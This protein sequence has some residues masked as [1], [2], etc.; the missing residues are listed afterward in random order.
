V[1]CITVSDV[2]AIL[3]GTE[4]S[5]NSN[6]IYRISFNAVANSGF[7]FGVAQLDIGSN[8]LAQQ[9]YAA[10]LDDALAATA[11]NQPT[12]NRLIAYNGHS[13][14]DLDPNLSSTYQSDKD[15]LNTTVFSRQAAHNI[16]DTYTDQ[17]ITGDPLIEIQNFLDAMDAA[18]GTDSVFAYNNAQYALALAAITSIDNRFGNLNQTT[19]YFQT[20]QPSSIGDVRDRFMS[21]AGAN[22]GQWD[23]VEIGANLLSAADPHYTGVANTISLASA[24]GVLGAEN[25]DD[26]V[27]RFLKAQIGNCIDNVDYVGSDAAGF[28][29]GQFTVSGAFSFSGGIF[30]SSGGFPGSANTSSSF[31]VSNNTPG[32]VNLTATAHSAF[33]GAGV[34]HDA[35]VVSFTFENNNPNVGGIKFDVVFGSD[36]Y[37]E[38]SDTSFVDVAAIYVN[39]VNYALFNN[40]S[41]TPLSVTSPNVS[42]GNFVN[43]TGGAYGVEWDGFSHLL[44]IRAPVH[45]GD[46]LI[47]IGVAD[48]GDSVYDS[49]LYIKDI[50]TLTEGGL[51][52]GV[53]NV[54]DGDDS[55]NHLFATNLAEEINIYGG[56]NT[57]SGSPSQLNGD[58]ITEFGEDDLLVFDGVQFGPEDLGVTFGSAIL[59]VDTNDD[60]SK[61]TTVTLTGNF[62][63]SQ[64]TV[65]Q[66]DGSTE[67]SV[68]L[69][70]PTSAP[71]ITSN[72]G[73]DTGTVSVAENITAV[74]K[75]VAT[76]AESD[77]LTFSISGGADQTK[78][79]INASTGDL[80]FVA[81]PN[82]ESPA[83]VGA[84]NVYNVT[85]QVSDGTSTD[86]QQ[87]A[88]T[89]TN[90]NEPPV[91]TSKRGRRNG[92]CLHSRKYVS[93]YH[94][95]RDRSRRWNDIDLQHHRRCGFR[96]VFDWRQLWR[97]CV[98][99]GA[100]L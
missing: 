1:S 75:V 23:L 93:G 63:G 21:L 73:G 45:L 53:L 62:Q 28:L 46:N 2:K 88:V 37:P 82:F 14:Y 33:P 94:G 85:V 54:I 24:V 13:R 40:N 79:A 64:F 67:I 57:V 44:T 65:S 39:G 98:C 19:V 92:K 61:D 32:D 48:T 16:I 12:Y 3:L 29:V 51:G 84:D 8:G 100:E 89:V 70:L 80:A 11:I 27:T 66:G 34:T 90:V 95:C 83:D 87:I 25:S 55:N 58:V 78:F 10:I 4:L 6:A 18:W 97:T 47:K 69:A 52:G 96:F 59:A 76:D 35:S 42:A 15:L 41:A 9:A 26:V 7:S 49:G 68:K 74:T 60:G 38:F 43:N 20:H 50:K 56:A 86:Q 36:E 77:P 5:G 30:L 31:S 22:Q 81:T 72:G 99:L 71:V 17:Y 91:I